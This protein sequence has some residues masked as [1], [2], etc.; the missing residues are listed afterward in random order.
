MKRND[1]PAWLHDEISL[2]NEINETSPGT[3]LKI[4]YTR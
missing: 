4:D 1:L 2:I 3:K